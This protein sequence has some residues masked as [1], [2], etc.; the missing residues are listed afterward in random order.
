MKIHS[1]PQWIHIAALGLLL[2]ACA[3]R[4]HAGVNFSPQ[5]P[6]D[7]NMAYSYEFRTADMNGDGRMDIIVSEDSAPRFYWFERMPTLVPQYIRHQVDVSYGYGSEFFVGDVNGDGWVDLVANGISPTNTSVQNVIWYRSSGGPNP[8]FSAQVIA[9][10]N[11]YGRDNLIVDLDGDGDM[12]IVSTS[13]YRETLRWHENLGGPDPQ[14]TTHLVCN[15]LKS[16]YIFTVT[17]ADM[18]GDGDMD[19]LSTTD[20]DGKIAWHEN[21]GANPPSFTPHEIANMGRNVWNVA[22]GDLDGD[23][24]QDVVALNSNNRDYTL[25]WYENG[26]GSQP[27]FTPHKVVTS[28]INPFRVVVMDLDGDGDQDFLAIDSNDDHVLFYENNGAAN[29]Y[30]QERSLFNDYRPCSLI[31]ADLEGDGDLDLLSLNRPAT[32]ES[33][34]LFWY[35]NLKLTSTAYPVVAPYSGLAFQGGQ[36]GPFA[37]LNTTYEVKNPT[38]NK[39][40]KWK[41]NKTQPWLDVRPTS[42]T[43]SP[44]QVVFVTVSINSQAESLAAGNYRDDI[45]FDSLD[46]ER[47]VTMREIKLSVL[48]RALNFLRGPSDVG[49]VSTYS[50]NFEVVDL[51]GDGWEDLVTTDWSGNIHWLA[52]DPNQ[53]L[54]FSKHIFPLGVDGSD[55]ISIGDLDGDGDQDIVMRGSDASD[56]QQLFWQENQGLPNPGFITHVVDPV[57]NWGRDTLVTDLDRDGDNDIVATSTYNICNMFWYENNG[58]VPPVF[59]RHLVTNQLRGEQIYS[60]EAADFDGNGTLDLLSVTEKDNQLAWLENRLK[61][62]QS[63]APHTIWQNASYRICEA[64]P[65]DFDRDGDS[66]ILAS[67][68]LEFGADAPGKISWFENIREAGLSRFVE[69]VIDTTIIDPSAPDAA[70][71]DGDGDLDLFVN[72][73]YRNTD[74]VYFIENLGGSPPQFI[75]NLFIKGYRPRDLRMA[76]LD[77]DGDPDFILLHLA[78]FQIYKNHPLLLMQPLGP[79]Y[80]FPSDSP[81]KVAWRSDLQRSGPDVRLELWNSQ[82]FT[83]ALGFDSDP[84]GNGSGDVRLPLVPEGKDYRI[85]VIS[86]QHPLIFDESPQPLTITGGPMRLTIPEGQNIWVAGSEGLVEW[87]SNPL[88]SGTEVTFELW[89]W[90][91]K[92][93]DLGFGG[94]ADGEGLCAVQVPSVAPGKD[95]KVRVISL[96]VPS[97][98]AESTGYVTIQNDFYR[99]AVRNRAWPLYQ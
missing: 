87:R 81:I 58:A 19:L 72:C 59:T 88:Y 64:K 25:Q 24:D 57:F 17:C 54:S 71:L 74:K 38:T 40:L 78:T 50:Y 31:P 21:N 12:D 49:T 14:F 1:Y 61:K 90:G 32:D 80:S 5:I 41:V 96:R 76:D 94:S 28:M 95:Y 48:S 79:P 37:P 84:K 89:R 53:P 70:D 6:I 27:T 22:A 52:Q 26:G 68:Y 55:N 92:I 3:N 42:G 97:W 51:N 86:I 2:L 60:V 91:R 65:L 82:G 99:N 15:T 30:F 56:K 13:I 46:L 9:T 47:T 36:G 35:Q 39:M 16:E 77:H 29:P 23:G 73:N 93:A 62:D 83:C 7:G 18:D 33:P 44:H 69:H 85:R 63:F 43:L 34:D 67:F 11:T 75:P 8:T 66:D 98:Y 4:G 20:E 10:D 45:Q